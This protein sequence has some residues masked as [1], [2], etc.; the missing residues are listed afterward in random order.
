MNRIDAIFRG[1]RERGAKALM[2]FVTAGDGG[3]DTTA[4]VLAAMQAGGASICEVGIPFSDPVADGPTIQ[5][6]MTRALDAGTRVEHVFETIAKARPSLSVGL[7][8]M[9]SYSIV[10]R[11]GLDQFVTSAKSAGFDGFI[12]PD[13]PLDEADD[14]R[15]ATREAGMILS[16]LVAPTTPIERAKQIAAASSGFVYVVARRGVT[17]ERQ[18]LAE[19]LPGRLAALRS[20]TDAPLAVGFGVSSAQQV[21]QVVQTADAAIV[22]SAL[23]RRM[24][25]V[26]EQGG[27]SV[28]EAER[29]TRELA[30]GLVDSAGVA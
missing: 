10:Y 1:L 20:V 30:G 19:D 27:D 15:A 26:I 28:Q 3:L 29:F 22:A 24:Q 8:A 2:P 4:R 21:S 6:S 18:S 7:V 9:V 5:A 25:D 14:A 16:M 17:G 13:L 23:I 12:F 11:M